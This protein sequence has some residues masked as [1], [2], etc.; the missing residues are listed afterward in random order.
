LILLIVLWVF[1]SQRLRTSNVE[2]M[3]EYY[4]EMQRMNA[5]LER[6]AIALEKRA[7]TSA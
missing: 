7:G 3:N 5:L 4:E 2:Q 1:W 6:I